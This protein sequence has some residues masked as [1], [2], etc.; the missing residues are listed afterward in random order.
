MVS[1]RLCSL[2]R[3]KQDEVICA[4]N[5][6]GLYNKGIFCP[7]FQQLAIRCLHI[8]LHHILNVVFSKVRFIL[9]YCTPENCLEH[10]PRRDV[11]THRKMVQFGRTW[12]GMNPSTRWDCFLHHNH[13]QSRAGNKKMLKY[14]CVMEWS[15]LRE[16]EVG[17]DGAAFVCGIRLHSKNWLW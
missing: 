10:P 9:S 1:E 7:L 6:R 12:V 13:Q 16:L 14:R 15:R 8:A 11:S 17:A 2:C 5:T 4:E 3:C